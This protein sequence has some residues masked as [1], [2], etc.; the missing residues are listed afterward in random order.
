MNLVDLLEMLCDW[1]SATM[2]HPEKP[3]DLSKSI[4]IL[5]ERYNISPQLAKVLYNTAHD[6]EMI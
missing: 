4:Q 2:N 3:G 1:K 6:F 5:G